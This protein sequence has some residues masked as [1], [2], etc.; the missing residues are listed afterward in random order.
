[1]HEILRREMQNPSKFYMLA[2]CRRSVKIEHVSFS[3]SKVCIYNAALVACCSSEEK[4]HT[5][6][7]TELLHTLFSGKH[8]N[9]SGMK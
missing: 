3:S 2:T 8:Y 5:P 4:E 6:H 7:R 1:M 9:S